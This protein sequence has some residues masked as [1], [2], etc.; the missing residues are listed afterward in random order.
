[1]SCLLVVYMLWGLRSWGKRPLRIGKLVMCE[2]SLQ[3]LS[4][5]LAMRRFFQITYVY[6]QCWPDRQHGHNAAVP[7]NGSLNPDH[8]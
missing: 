6:N 1:M 7:T 8:S 5:Y 3:I 2:K 4:N